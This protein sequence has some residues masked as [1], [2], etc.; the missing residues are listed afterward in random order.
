[1]ARDQ[2]KKKAWREAN[3]EKVKA[4]SKAY[5]EAHKE[6]VEASNK[7]YYEAHKE[8][9]RAWRK[10]HVVER[11]SQGAAYY[12]ANKDEVREKHRAYY[13]KTKDARR[14]HQKARYSEHRDEI[15]S[16]ARAAYARQRDKVSAA[17]K[18][19]RAEDPERFRTYSVR[20]RACKQTSQGKLLS[21][22]LKILTALLGTK[23]LACGKAE[24]TWDHIKPL[25]RGGA[26]GPTNLQPLCQSCN[27]SK[28]ARR[29]TDY[30]TSAQVKA[31]L[32]AFQLTLPF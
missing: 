5:R 32:A 8:E 10:E 28:G 7:A 24:L 13:E 11:R 30:R 6:K 2:E 21:S 14:V 4:Y 18:I 17:R 22:D 3:P 31:V 1:M 29:S 16:Q 19:R 12:E 27:A 15:L 26:N 23:C 9:K 20:R 25:S